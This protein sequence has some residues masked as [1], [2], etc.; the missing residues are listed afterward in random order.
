MSSAGTSHGSFF[1]SVVVLSFNQSIRV[2]EVSIGDGGHKVAS[3]QLTAGQQMLLRSEPHI[4]NEIQFV[5]F[6]SF[7]FR[8]SWW[9]ICLIQCLS[10]IDAWLCIS[11]SD[12]SRWVAFNR[13]LICRMLHSR[14]LKEESDDLPGIEMVKK[15]P[16][17]NSKL[18]CLPLWVIFVETFSHVSANRESAYLW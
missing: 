14:T 1:F 18:Q 9:M 16:S 7:G 17:Q 5:F 8:R 11:P 10:F 13:Y 2:V 15:C 6:F 4:G 3:R 12:L